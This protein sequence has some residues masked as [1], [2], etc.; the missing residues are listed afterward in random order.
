VSI[1]EATLWSYEVGAH[2]GF[3]GGDLFVE[4]AVYFN[5]YQDYPVQGQIANATAILVVEQVTSVGLD[6][7]MQYYTPIE[8]LRL[9]FTGDYNQTEPSA[10]DPAVEAQVPSLAEGQQLPYVPQW[11]VNATAGYDWALANALYGFTYASLTRRDGQ[12]DLITNVKS[13]VTNDVTLRL[14]VR[15]PE[16]RW[17]VSLF[18]KNL[19]DDVGPAV[20]T[21]GLEVRYNR[22][23]IGVELTARVPW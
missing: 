16:D 3:L 6:L 1:P 8:G 23:T 22:R 21:G 19:T 10:V 18:A 13:P 20:T 14:G 5:D 11:A 2:F 17:S 15:N 12:F 4:P 9:T 7:L